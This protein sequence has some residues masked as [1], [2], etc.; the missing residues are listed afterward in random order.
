MK[1]G[2][3]AVK[4]VLMDIKEKIIDFRYSERPKNRPNCPNCKKQL[5]P[6]GGTSDGEEMF[7]VCWDCGYKQEDYPCA[8]GY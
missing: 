6:A 3:S 7:W 5:S 8:Y 2:Y 1:Q 4:L